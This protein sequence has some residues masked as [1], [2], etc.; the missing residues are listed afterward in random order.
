MA[1]M[2]RLSAE[3]LSEDFTPYQI[4]TSANQI[5][6]DLQRWWQS[7]PPAL[8]DQ[9]TDWRRQIRPTKLTVPETLQEEGMSSIR[10]CMYGCVI[11]INHIM[12]PVYKEPQSPQVTEAIREILGIAKETP[13]GYGLEMGLYFGLFMA[14]IAVF[15]DSETEDLL[16]RKMKADTRVS[17]Y[18]RSLSSGFMRLAD[19]DSMRIAPLNYW[20]S[21]GE[22]NTDMESNTTGGKYKP[23]WVSKCTSSNPFTISSLFSRKPPRLALAYPCSADIFSRDATTNFRMFTCT[24]R[25]TAPS[26]VDHEAQSF[27]FHRKP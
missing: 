11:Y 6:N 8:R 20:K 3:S 25:S 1:R 10:S 2:S 26:G 12:N 19:Y 4:Q 27:T 7:C 16:R 21:F 18:V 14:G 24:K 5:Y 9:P 17:I 15:N 22:D 13:E 23:K